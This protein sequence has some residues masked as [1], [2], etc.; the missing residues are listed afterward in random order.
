MGAWTW[1]WNDIRTASAK[2]VRDLLSFMVLI[3]AVCFLLLLLVVQ[4][5]FITPVCGC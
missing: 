2:A 1:P 4:N 5:E 3:I